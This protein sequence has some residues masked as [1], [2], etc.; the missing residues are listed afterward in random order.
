MARNDAPATDPADALAA[1][2]L[3]EIDDQLLRRIKA[4]YDVSDPVPGGLVERL[5]FGITLDALEA[6]IANLQRADSTLAGARTDG[7]TE[8]QTVTFTSASLTTMITVTPSGADRAR[9]DGWSAPG[10]GL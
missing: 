4:M 10:A 7:A 5:Q 8:V 9:I 1:A 6:E 2:P 3:D